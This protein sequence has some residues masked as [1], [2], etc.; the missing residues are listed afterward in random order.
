MYRKPEKLLPGDRVGIFLAASPIKE[1]FRTQGLKIVS[2]DLGFVPV[3]V[4]APESRHG[5]LARPPERALADFQQFY[6]DDW[7]K[8]LW[9]GRG[10]YGSN[11]LLPLLRRLRATKPKVVIG[12]SDISGLLWYLLEHW[13]MVVFYGPMIYSTLAE[14][15][16]ERRQLLAT[17]AGDYGR[18]EIPGRVLT[19]GRATGLAAGG[20]LTTL[21]TLIGTPYLPRLD[22][23]VLL[24]EDVNEKPYRLDRMFW[25][26][27]HSGLLNKVHGLLLGEFPGCFSSP[28]EKEAFWRDQRDHLPDSHIPMLFDMPFGHSQNCHTLPLGVKVRID[29]DDFTGLIIEEKGVLE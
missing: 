22:G 18:M 26:L 16:F 24:L 9:A 1:P 14:S 7:I 12:S 4:D 8:A 17:L 28:D 2:A 13:R 3:E 29:T 20:C 15:R 21:I 23:R 5:L 10:G 27:R 6:Q 19:P 11:Y 25:Q